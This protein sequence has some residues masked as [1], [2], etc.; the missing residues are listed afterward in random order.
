MSLAVLVPVLQ[1]PHHV[2]PLV[3]AFAG[4]TTGPY[5]IVFLTDPG[6]DEERAAVASV[7][8]SYRVDEV[9]CGGSYAQKIREGVRATDEPLVFLGAD[10]LEPERG[11]LEA[12]R[13][14]IREGAQVVGVNDLL[15]RNRNHATHFLMTREYAERPTIDG[16]P[17]P[18][19]TG[20]AHWFCDDELI[21]T[22]KKRGVYAYAE[23]SHVRHLHPMDGRTP[24]DETY[25]KG[26][27][28]ARHDRRIFQRREVL[29]S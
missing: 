9:C 18:L 29:W 11:W 26:R 25:R 20:Y 22:A 14:K 12:A 15:R 5:R 1:R 28:A 24:D 13:A 2:E 10:D 8:D 6:D 23:D 7:A 19:F 17:G 4:A 16:R 21:A 3:R 27:A